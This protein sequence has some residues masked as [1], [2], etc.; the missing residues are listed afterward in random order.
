VNGSSQQLIRRR[1]IG[2]DD[3]RQAVEALVGVADA[4]ERQVIRRVAA[5]LNKLGM[6][7]TNARRLR[8]VAA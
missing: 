3:L 6:T 2:A 1:G 4:G 8:T 7:K 5:R